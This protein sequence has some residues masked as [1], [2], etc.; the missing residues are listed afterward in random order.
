M[1]KIQVFTFNPFQEN[2]YVLSDEKGNCVII[3]P[4]CSSAHERTV[5]DEYIRENGLKP[6]ALLNTHAHIDHVFG[7]EHVLRTYNVPFYLHPLDLPVLKMAGRSAEVYGIPGFTESPLPDHELADGQELVFGDIRLRVLFAP[8]HAPGHVVF[9]DAANKYLVNGDVLFKG[10]FGR[11]DLPGG[12]QATLKRSITEVLFRLP[13]D[14][15]VFTGHGPSTTI[16]EEQQSNPI[17][18]Y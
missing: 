13:E 18:H 7:N 5:L 10:S 1:V 4:G 3:D 16:G 9:H 17:W 8:G 6:L 12:D 2:M 14:T 11:T 15:V